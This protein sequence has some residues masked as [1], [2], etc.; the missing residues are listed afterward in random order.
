VVSAQLDAATGRRF[1]ALRLLRHASEYPTLGRD[2][3]D[4]ESARAAIDFASRV[5]PAVIALI[6]QMGVFR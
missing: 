2:G 1:R 5:R 3:A 4:A 6:A